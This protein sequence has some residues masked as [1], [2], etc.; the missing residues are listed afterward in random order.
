MTDHEIQD[1]DAGK[2]RD[3][4]APIYG[5]AS[6]LESREA[7]AFEATRDLVGDWM[8]P[9]TGDAGLGAASRQALILRAVSTA[10]P[11]TVSALAGHVMIRRAG[12][13]QAFPLGADR[14]VRRGDV[15]IAPH[16]GRALISMPDGSE[17]LLRAESEI[18]IGDTTPGALA[19]RMTLTAGRVYA[20]IAKQKEVLFS[21][22]TNVGF[23]CVVGTE[24]DLQI[25]REGNLD[26][27]VSH[28]QVNFRPASASAEEVPLR[29]NEM[30]EYRA[31]RTSKRTLTGRETDARTAWAR[32]PK[33][34]RV[35][36]AVVA[37]VLAVCLAVGG[38]FYVKSRTDY[39]P[40]VASTS[41]N[42]QT[43]NGA[44]PSNNTPASEASDVFNFTASPAGA[45]NSVTTSISNGEMP[46]VGPVEYR[47]YLRTTSQPGSPTVRIQVMDGSDM[48]SNS[49]QPLPEMM[50]SY[51]KMRGLEMEFTKDPSGMFL[52]PKLNRPDTGSDAFSALIFTATLNSQP[53]DRAGVK[54]GDSWTSRASGSIS[55]LPGATYEVDMTHRF[56]GFSDTAEGRVAMVT[57]KGTVTLL[58]AAI[59]TETTRNYTQKLMA[60]S[61]V[62]DQST[63][64]MYDPKT[65]RMISAINNSTTKMDMEMRILV[66][67]RDPIINKIPAVTTVQ[68]GTM[69][70]EY[71]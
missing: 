59:S 68:N 15:V 66:V 21:I 61:M 48:L 40:M 24:F 17:I 65:S 23:A 12:A 18:E 34:G 29:R 51:A 70:V 69:H 47:M 36:G 60:N 1:T 58:N 64:A 31:S 30:V 4:L 9:T 56:D 13:A 5:E 22:R 26:L 14:E 7:A 62:I 6:T 50:N 16:G 54:K 46:G 8:K 63:T 67:G 53:P 43:T 32:K 27:I 57:S 39:V 42:G 49:G 52:D 71:Q 3:M 55:A 10:P 20:W 2:A 35:H 41:P 45:E 38:V 37:G 44:A 33:R 11:A 28:G 25:D 19:E